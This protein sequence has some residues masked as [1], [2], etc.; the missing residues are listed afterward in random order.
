MARVVFCSASIGWD[1]KAQALLCSATLFYDDVTL[2]LDTAEVVN[3]SDDT[4]ATFAIEDT[5]K[6]ASDPT[7]TK[8]QDVASKV[9]AK[10]LTPITAVQLKRIPSQIK[11]QP[12][13]IVA[14]DGF[15]FA[16]S[17]PVYKVDPAKAVKDPGVKA[18]G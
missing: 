7:R 16:F 17:G 11:G 8:A 10:A 6:Q 9:T 18:G 3:G 5:T 1:E 14:P 2:I 12:D 4:N 15:T 13:Q